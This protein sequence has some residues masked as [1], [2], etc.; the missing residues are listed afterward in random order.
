M[1]GVAGEDLLRPVELFQQHAAAQQMRPGHRAQG[2]HLIGPV[3]DGGPEPL[4][5]ANREGEGGDAGIAPFPEPVGEIAARPLP[6]AGVE[7]NEAGGGGQRGEDQLGLAPLQFGRRETALFFQFD[8]RRARG[9]PRG[10]VCL[11]LIE[12]AAAKPADGK[13]MDADGRD[14]LHRHVG[15][16]QAGAPH[17]FEIVVGPDL[18]PEDVDDHVAGID[19]HPIALALA[20]DRDAAG[21]ILLQMLGQ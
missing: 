14:L 19:Q 8:D 1:I 21:Q 17:L 15:L 6:A 7:G 2:Q 13:D 10:I 4:G 18:R 9:D 5:A 11:Q 12:R 3:D 16:R 20:L